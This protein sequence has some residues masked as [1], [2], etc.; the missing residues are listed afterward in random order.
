MTQE[1]MDKQKAQEEANRSSQESNASGDPGSGADG[2]SK[3]VPLKALQEEREKRKALQ[4][5]LEK[6]EG[7]PSQTKNGEQQIP[8][9]KL[10]TKDL[11]DLTPDQLEDT[12]NEV[13]T[14]A[15]Q[16]ALESTR[17]EL[18]NMQSRT[19]VDRTIAKFA[20]FGDED[21]KLAGAALNDLKERIEAN[22]ETP[23]EELAKATAQDWS[24]YKVAAKKSEKNDGKEIKSGSQAPLPAAGGGAEVA[25]LK[26]ERKPVT[27][28]DDVSAAADKKA[29]AWEQEQRARGE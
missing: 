25:H 21:R 24:K 22:P 3:T 13:V 26:Q 6:L 16:A 20:I 29:A 1:E 7:K 5:K 8:R 10:K 19:E 18:V 9:I 4:A 28:F 23:L 2:E 27:S 15:V 12:L 11:I 17:G 14:T